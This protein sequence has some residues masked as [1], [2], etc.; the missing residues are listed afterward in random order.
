MIDS[1]T[2][3]TIVAV[4]ATR[5]FY[6]VGEFHSGGSAMYGNKAAKRERLAKIAAVVA[7]STG[8]ITQAALA[9][10][11]GVARSTI[12]KD[13]VALERCGIRLA[14]DDKGRLSWPG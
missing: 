14:E 2:P 5:Y 4:L 8:G 9:K 12:N 13:L 7:Q 10:A 11:L 1:R 6:A 3:L